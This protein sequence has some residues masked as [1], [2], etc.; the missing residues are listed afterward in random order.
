MQLP[1]FYEPSLPSATGFY[2]LS[3]TTSKHCAQVLRM[4]AG[5][6]LLLT[7]GNGLLATAILSVPHKSKSQV[8]IDTI[9][10]HE[11]SARKTCIAIG[12]LKNNARMDWFLEKATELGISEIIPM[13]TDHTEKTHFRHDRASA[14]LAAAM[15]QSQQTFLPLL[16]EP[17]SYQKAI[18]QSHYQQQ[19]IAHCEDKIKTE[20]AHIPIGNDVQLFIGPEGDF[21]TEEINLAEKKGFSPVALGTNR[22]RTET[23]GI[24]GA[25][26]LTLN[27]TQS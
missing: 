1:Y 23:A 4:Q 12:L 17:T 26:L 16:H 6:R 18:E 8:Q 19:F 27:I 24:A 7:D 3:E 11:R 9:K 5:S 14:V 2:T 22:L 25:V 10:L 21:S 20:L 15:I 13:V